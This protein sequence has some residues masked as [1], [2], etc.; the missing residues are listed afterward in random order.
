MHMQIE[1]VKKVP[2][3]RD[4]TELNP[5]LRHVMELIETQLKIMND[6]Q[7]GHILTTKRKPPDDK[8]SK[9]NNNSNSSSKGKSYKPP[10]LD[11]IS[12]LTTDF[13]SVH[14]LS[15]LQGQT[16]TDKL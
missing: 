11:P 1:W 2:K 8:V 12:T 9:N 15:L 5:T 4:E 10:P 13:E 7:Y 16:F 14:S 6:P 3:I